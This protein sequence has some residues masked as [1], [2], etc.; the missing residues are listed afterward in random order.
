MPRDMQRRVSRRRWITTGLAAGSGLV[1]AAAVAV[2]VPAITGAVSGPNTSASSP[3]ASAGY[4][5]SSWRL[6]SVAEKASSVTI[7]ADI[8]A[9]MNLLPDGQILVDDGVNTVSGRFT[10]TADGFEVRGFTSTTVG[11]GGKNPIRLAAIAA[12]RAL[13]GDTA[14]P[15]RDTVVSAARTRLVVEAGAYRLTFE[16][17]GPATDT[18]DQPTP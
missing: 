15:A 11:Y 17:T 7:P 4:V 9:Q 6:T 12:V 10:T 5:G 14:A 2:A 8:G 13:V 18:P 3:S 1:A 16:R